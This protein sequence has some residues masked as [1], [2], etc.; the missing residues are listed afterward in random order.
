MKKILLLFLLFTACQKDEV[1]V[2]PQGIYGDYTG[3]QSCQPTYSSNPRITVSANDSKSVKLDAL[4]P[5]T[6][7][8]VIVNCEGSDLKIPSQTFTNTGSGAGTV[9]INGSGEYNPPF[10]SLNVNVSF[11]VG[12]NYQCHVLL[13]K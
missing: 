10:I 11:S 5:W 12:D 9:T 1:Q 7:N 13:S 8:A 4:R 6:P 3:N 2:I